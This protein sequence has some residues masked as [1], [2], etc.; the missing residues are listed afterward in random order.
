M[1]IVQLQNFISVFINPLN[2]RFQ[3]EILICCPYSF[4]S[5]FF[6]NLQGVEAS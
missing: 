6:L 1:H 3:I 2:P 5:D 4:Q